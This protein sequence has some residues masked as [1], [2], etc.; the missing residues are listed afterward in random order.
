MAAQREEEEE[1][2]K[3]EGEKRGIF[4]VFFFEG[5]IRG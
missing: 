4:D 1:E 5:Q 3:N 2:E